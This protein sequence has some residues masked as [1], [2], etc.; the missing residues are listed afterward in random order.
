MPMIILF[1]IWFYDCVLA[2]GNKPFPLRKSLPQRWKIYE[3]HGEV[4]NEIF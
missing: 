1:L 3:K 2:W 4:T